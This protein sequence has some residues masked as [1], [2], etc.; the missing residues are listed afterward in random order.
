MYILALP[1]TIH[2]ISKFWSRLL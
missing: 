2:I 1:E